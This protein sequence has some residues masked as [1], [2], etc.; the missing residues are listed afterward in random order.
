MGTRKVA[1][2]NDRRYAEYRAS[3]Q[4]G[5][6][7]GGK[8]RIDAQLA[9]AGE[10]VAALA[11]AQARYDSARALLDSWFEW[12]RA[13]AEARTAAVTLKAAET[14]EGIARLRVRQGDAA[15]LD[16][17]LAAGAT[18]EA[19]ARLASARAL[20]DALAADI[21]AR[22]TGLRAGWTPAR[23]EPADPGA[24]EPEPDRLARASA[25]LAAARARTRQAQ[26][27]ARR[28]EAERLPDPTLGVNVG[29]EFGGDEQFVGL[30]VS[31]PIG[32]AARAASMESSLAA[33]RAAAA[34]EAAVERA[35]RAEAAR[36][37]IT[38]R[39]S[40][41]TWQ[42][43]REAVEAQRAATAL[44]ER[45][46]SLGEASITELITARRTL[47]QLELSETRARL[48]ALEAQ[49]RWLLQ[50]R[51]MWLEPLPPG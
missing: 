37:V 35:L 3:L 4:R 46:W 8:A 34:D 30:S 51:A 20:Q 7:I 2:D 45:A 19:Q 44:Q 16:A 41:E 42:R 1:P 17:E 6:R 5:L 18:A 12:L 31:V 50:T 11:L 39:G 26:L 13:T 10:Q 49:S 22:F 25:A 38:L 28:S 23:V 33:A 24:L 9:G 14:L 47:E 21:D 40:W 48:D 29:T 32:G 15:R 27:L 36:A 43:L